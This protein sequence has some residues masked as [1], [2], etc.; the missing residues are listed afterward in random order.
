M[1]VQWMLTNM[2]DTFCLV[3][4][5]SRFMVEGMKEERLSCL[6]IVQGYVS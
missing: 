3:A 4:W 6:L 2:Y 1:Y 5:I